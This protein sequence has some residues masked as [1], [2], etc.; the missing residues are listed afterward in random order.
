MGDVMKNSLFR[1]GGAING[2]GWGK[3]GK[4]ALVKPLVQLGPRQCIA[5]KE[6]SQSFRDLCNPQ[7]VLTMYCFVQDKPYLR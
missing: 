2:T 1:G 4:I 6:Q 3:F 5:P 7:G